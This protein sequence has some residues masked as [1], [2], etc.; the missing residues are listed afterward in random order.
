[1]FR[2]TAGYKS[3]D[4]KRSETPDNLTVAERVEQENLQWTVNNTM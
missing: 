1:V 2:P 4:E 3:F